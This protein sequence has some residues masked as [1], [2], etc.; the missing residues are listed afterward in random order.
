MHYVPL[1]VL[2]RDFSKKSIIFNLLL[3]SVYLYYLRK[4]NN[5]IIDV[6]LNNIYPNDT[7]I[8]NYYNIAFNNIYLGIFYTI[9]SCYLSYKYLK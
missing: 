9:V 8:T 1:M 4:N 7:T 5:N 2:K 6:Y 3:F